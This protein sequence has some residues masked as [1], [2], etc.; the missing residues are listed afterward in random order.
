MDIERKKNI[1]FLAGSDSHECI[2]IQRD[3]ENLEVIMNDKH[4]KLME[5]CLVDIYKL[6]E[7]LKLKIKTIEGKITVL[8]Q[9]DDNST[10]I[11]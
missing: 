11:N 9:S 6:L 8:E 2:E 7:K 1:I 5:D 3:T 10:L 4:C